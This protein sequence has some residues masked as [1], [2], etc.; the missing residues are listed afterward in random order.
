MIDDDALIE[1]SKRERESFSPLLEEEEEEEVGVYIYSLLTNFFSDGGCCWFAAGLSGLHFRW[2]KNT[3]PPNTALIASVIETYGGITKKTEKGEK[4][5]LGDCSLPNWIRFPLMTDFQ[6]LSIYNATKGD[7]VREPASGLQVFLFV[8]FFYIR[9]L[10]FVRLIPLKVGRT[11][12]PTKE[13]EVNDTHD[14]CVCRMP[15]AYQYRQHQKQKGIS[16]V[17]IRR[18]S[19][20]SH[21]TCRI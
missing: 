19:D 2:T 5:K 20:G 15:L 6:P 12:A 11:D 18:K 21:V 1:A 16:K 7:S 9:N 13:E 8:F 17:E 14:L 4:Q 3:S 10:F